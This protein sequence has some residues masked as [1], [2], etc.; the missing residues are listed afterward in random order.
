MLHLGL[1]S[2]HR[3]HQAV[4]LHQLQQSGDMRWVL[5]GGN[6]RPD[7]SADDIPDLLALGAAVLGS[8]T[9]PAKPARRR[10]LSLLLDGLNPARATPL[11][12]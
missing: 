9:R 4:Y 8:T 11:P 10:Y 3:A 6:I 5:A 2:F 7:I 12:E 1:G